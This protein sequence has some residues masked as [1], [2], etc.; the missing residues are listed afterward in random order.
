MRNLFI[1]LL[2]ILALPMSASAQDVYADSLAPKPSDEVDYANE[3]TQNLCAYAM[4]GR[5]YGKG[6]N[7]SA[8]D[9]IVSQIKEIGH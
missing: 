5:G 6:G 9:Y 1:L 4:N 8:A 2:A 7:T 3:I